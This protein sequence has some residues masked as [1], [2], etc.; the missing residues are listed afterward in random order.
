MYNKKYTWNNFKKSV[1]AM[2]DVEKRDF[3]EKLKIDYML[4]KSKKAQHNPQTQVKI[5]RRQIAYMK[6]ILHEQGYH[7]NPRG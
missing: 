4:E 3:L 6:T 1:S 2:T 5:L 7:Y